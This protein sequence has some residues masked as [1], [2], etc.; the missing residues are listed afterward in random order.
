MRLERGVPLQGRGNAKVNGATSS[1]PSCSAVQVRGARDGRHLCARRL[2]IFIYARPHT[3]SCVD[4]LRIGTHDN[5]TTCRASSLPHHSI[6]RSSQAPLYPLP[7][8]VLYAHT[9]PI[10]AFAKSNGKAN[11]ND[12]N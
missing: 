12:V 10:L 8:F 11:V 2:S 4:L 7:S 3:S 1:A 6:T 5:L 9:H